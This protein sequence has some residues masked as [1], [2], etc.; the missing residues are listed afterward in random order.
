MFIKIHSY[1]VKVQRTHHLQGK[2]YFGEEREENEIQK[3]YTKGF[4]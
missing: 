1:V 4:E 3:V 2:D